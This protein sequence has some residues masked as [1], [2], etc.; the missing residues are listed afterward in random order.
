MRGMQGTGV[1]LQQ[2]QAVAAWA[3]AESTNAHTKPFATARASASTAGALRRRKLPV[4]WQIGHNRALT[5]RLPWTRGSLGALTTLAL[6]WRPNPEPR[7]LGR[8]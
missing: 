8:P 6:R 2:V 5:A 7:S 4:Q 1:P 3:W